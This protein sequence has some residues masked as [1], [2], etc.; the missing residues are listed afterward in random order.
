MLDAYLSQAA[1]CKTAN[2]FNGLHIR[3]EKVLAPAEVCMLIDSVR[4]RGIAVP[5]AS[6]RWLDG[7]DTLLRG[8]GRRVQGYARHVLAEGA[9]AYAAPG[10]DRARAQRTLV[11]AFTGGANRLMM[12]VALF[13]QHCPA[14]RYEFVVL[15]DRTRT[16][17]L[18]GVAGLGEDLPATI[19]RLRALCVPS[20]FRRVVSF[21]TS[22]G[23]LAAV[24]T[25]VALGCERAVSVGGQ[26]PVQ[27]AERYQTQNMNTEGFDVALRSATRLPEVLLVVGERAE[28]DREKALTMSALIPAT[29]IVIPGTAHHNVLYDA[30]KAGSLDALLDQLLGEG[31]A[32]G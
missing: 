1:L 18:S 2:E 30:W 13:L 12:P 3:L 10:D 32:S 22:A 4:E 21:G 20:S 14:E 9:T 7:M 5:P 27:I 29:T 31:K 16:F 11:F 28:R 19:E 25:G 6:Q 24:W 26:S 8:G 17:Y 15:V 23:G